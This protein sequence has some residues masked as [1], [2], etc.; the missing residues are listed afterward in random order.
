VASVFEGYRSVRERLWLFL[1]NLTLLRK[2][3]AQRAFAKPLRL[4][5]YFLLP[6][7]RQKSL[8]VKKGPAMG[9]VFDLN[10]RWEHSAWEGI[11]EE[12]VQQLFVKFSKPGTVVFDLGANY[13][14]YAMLA[15]REGADVFAFEP[16]QEN[17]KAL[18]RHAAMNDLVSRVHIIP[19]A[20]YSYTGKIEI[21]PPDVGS[22]HGNAHT[23][24][25]GSKTLGAS[26]VTCTTL[27]DF[28]QANPK[29]NFL[30]M[31]VEGAESEVLKGA[32]RLFRTSR[33]HLLCEIHDQPNATFAEVWLGEH[34]Y[35]C[36]WLDR[37]RSFPRHLF[38]SP[39]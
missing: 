18:A 24:H 30:K 34:D 27:D 36:M 32:D 22:S 1:R 12:S 39:R 14:F 10:P 37:E 29:P 26:Y 9:L 28:V 21:E 11:Y 4:A 31:D 5:S 17:A 8:R 25:R 13:G 33:P 20:V 3:Y 35:T 16:D 23:R 15:A 2:L 38:A 19:S 7:N 6:S